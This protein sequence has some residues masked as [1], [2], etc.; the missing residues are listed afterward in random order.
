MLQRLTLNPELANPLNVTEGIPEGTITFIDTTNPYK[1]WY[2]GDPLE[3]WGIEEAYRSIDVVLAL[4]EEAVDK[5]GIDYTVKAVERGDEALVHHY[6]IDLTINEIITY[7]SDDSIEW[8]DPDTAAAWGYPDAPT[9]YEEAFDLFNG[10]FDEGSDIVIAVTGQETWDYWI[11]GLAPAT[12]VMG[13]NT[14]ILV[15]FV[16]YWTD[17]NIVQHE[18]AHCYN[19]NDHPEDLDLWC[20]MAG[21]AD[22]VWFLYEDGNLYDY[23]CNIP[24]GVMTYD[25]CSDCDDRLHDTGS[26]GGGGG[27]GGWLRPRGREDLGD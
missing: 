26:G 15:R 13:S 22:Y 18:V 24:R 7:E 14:L 8:M 2:N 3:E 11:A 4:D 9:L 6:I 17:D 20:P 23:F 16:I 19:C 25:W 10:E 21:Y 5:W 1:D 27:G 12:A